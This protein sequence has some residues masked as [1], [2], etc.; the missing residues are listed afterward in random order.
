[1]EHSPTMSMPKN[2]L[3]SDITLY[4]DF[5]IEDLVMD[6]GNSE[7]YK[8]KTV[9][10]KGITPSTKESNWEPLKSDPKIKVYPWKLGYD[11]WDVAKS[12]PYDGG[13]DSA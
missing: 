4:A 13:I 9:W 8:G 5:Y 3:N 2:T 6:G 12:Q 10:V 7:K 1:M 11:W